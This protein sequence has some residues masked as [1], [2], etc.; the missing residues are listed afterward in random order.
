MPT[1][2]GAE[3]ASGSLAVPVQLL[4]LL[5]AS[6][7]KPYV[8]PVLLGLFLGPASYRV[9]GCGTVNGPGNGTLGSFS[10]RQQKA[11]MRRYAPRRPAV[12]SG[13]LELSDVNRA[14]AKAGGSSPAT[15][16]LTPT[17]PANE[18]RNPIPIC[19]PLC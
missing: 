4:A 13:H 3:R 14:G 8:G 7:E 10:R 12:R 11:W 16:L 1:P 17:I 19:D 2:S 5:G 18:V 9:N 6:Y 15:S